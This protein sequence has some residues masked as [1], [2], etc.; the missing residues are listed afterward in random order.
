MERGD[1]HARNICEF[2]H[3]QRLGVVCLEPGDCARGSVAEIARGCD[4]AEAFSL[5]SS[6]NAVDNFALDQVAQ[7]GNVLGSFEKIDEPG[8]GVEQADRRLAYSNSARLS[9]G[10]DVQEIFAADDLTHGWHIETKKHGEQ[11]NSFRGFDDLTL[12]REHRWTR[13][14]MTIHRRDTRFLRG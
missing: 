11:G 14:G 13:E 12:Q 10:S 5:W 2:L 4:G 7:E 8:A 9:G 1:T 6:E 3:A